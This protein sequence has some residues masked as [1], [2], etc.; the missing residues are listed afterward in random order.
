MRMKKVLPVL[1][2]VL[3]LSLS[4]CGANSAELSDASEAGVPNE[5][6]ISSDV[7]ASTA[8]SE[9]NSNSEKEAA[10]GSAV[11]LLAKEYIHRTDQDGQISSYYAPIYTESALYDGFERYT[12][13]DIYLETV[14]ERTNEIDE[15]GRTLSY[16]PLNQ[17]ST[18]SF[19][20]DEAGRLTE[21][22]CIHST[23]VTLF[24][25]VFTYDDSG[26]LLKKTDMDDD[27]G[28]PSFEWNY[29][30]DD[31][32]NI[33]RREGSAGEWTEYTYDEDGY[34]LTAVSYDEDGEQEEVWSSFEYEEVNVESLPEFMGSTKQWI[35]ADLVY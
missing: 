29:I 32:G 4:G 34:P 14:E 23:D 2:C 24:W 5:S 12:P 7:S 9:Q 35:L 11:K 21:H 19:V 25:Y 18:T 10:S 15:A 1:T 30:Y 26:R 16:S 17:A 33:I 27:R 13:D 20:F 28:L 3:L 6:S 31:A 8:S 22:K